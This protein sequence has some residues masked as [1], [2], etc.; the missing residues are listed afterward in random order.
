MKPSSFLTGICILL[1]F[2]FHRSPAQ[3]SENTDTIDAFTSASKALKISGGTIFPT[4]VIVQWMEWYEDD[5]HVEAYQLQWGT[6]SGTFTDTINL[7]PFERKTVTTT[8]I[9]PLA[10]NTTYYARFYRVYEEEAKITEFDFKTPPLPDLIKAPV[11]IRPVYHNADISSFSI[12]SINGKLISQ[13]IISSDNRM[14]SVLNPATSGTYLIRYYSGKTTVMTIRR[15][16]S[17]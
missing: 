14:F 11:P 8:T 16:L 5:P 17:R 1:L 15:V 13:G 3:S 2:F 4:Y 12:Y 10:D 6:E 9:S 7:K